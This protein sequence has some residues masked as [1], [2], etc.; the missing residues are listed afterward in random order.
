LIA[1]LPAEVPAA[2]ED[3]KLQHRSPEHR[4]GLVIPKKNPDFA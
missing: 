3:D 2:L 1:H 4:L